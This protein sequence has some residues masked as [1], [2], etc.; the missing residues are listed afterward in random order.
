MTGAHPCRARHPESQPDTREKHEKL[1]AGHEKRREEKGSK[2]NP[3]PKVGPRM[4]AHR[5][6]GK[7]DPADKGM[8]A[9]PPRVPILSRRGPIGAC[10][11]RALGILVGIEAQS[12]DADR[13][14]FSW[15]EHLAK[16][17]M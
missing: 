1:R 16:T 5:H 15:L 14:C 17:P 4:R 11:R 7:V 10:G 6:A 8:R 3:R 2:D 9:M 13:Q 12:A